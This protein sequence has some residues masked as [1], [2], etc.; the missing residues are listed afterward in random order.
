MS[1]KKVNRS[2]DVFRNVM[3][4]AEQRILLESADASDFNHKSIVGD[5]RAASLAKFFQ[6]QLP[7]RFGVQKG[8]AV[9]HNDTRTGQL[10]FVIYDRWHC[11][12]IRVGNENLLLPCEALYC[13]VE[14]KTRITQEEL[15][16][17]Y[18]SAGKVRLLEPFGQPFIAARQDGADAD[19]ERA[20]CLYIVFGYKSNLAN[21]SD[22]GKK[23]FQRLSSASKS[24]GVSID[25]VDRL[26]VLDRGLIRPQI[27]MG[28]WQKDG[29]ESVFL[30]SYLHIIN[31]LGR[32]SERRRPV[33]WRIYGPRRVPGW[34]T[35]L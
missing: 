21:N 2:S 6:E 20:R 31:F 26:I 16:L 18:E 14:V 22:W 11:S 25:C 13:V 8:E 28:R 4:K 17:C 9:D 10:D 29:A 35:L 23:E 27:Q 15:N 3:K 7:E 30:E 12:P 24:A 32:E 19:D 33:D 1:K 34:K 5:E